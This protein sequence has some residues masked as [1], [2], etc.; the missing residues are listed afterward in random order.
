MK[1]DARSEVDTKRVRGRR[2]LR[3]SSFA[4][5]VVDANRLA[6]GPHRALG[7]WSLPQVLKHLG[8]AMQSSID[9]QGFPVKWY[10]RWLGPVVIKPWLIKGPFPA[11]FQLPR[12]G[13]AKLVAQ[14]TTTL[15]EGMAALL[16]GIERLA[17][18]A[19]RVSHPVVGKLTVLEWDQFHLRHAEMHMSFILPEETK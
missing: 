4:D 17:R 10:L 11:G 12:S 15:D 16:A 5:I 9:G 6:A 3:Y 1:V 18:E 2:K 7:N 8:N 13:A 14:D 19:S